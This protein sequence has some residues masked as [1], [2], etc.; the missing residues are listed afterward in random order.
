MQEVKGTEIDEIKKPKPEN[1]KNIKPENEMKMAS[2][3][4]NAE[5]FGKMNLK[6]KQSII[7]IMKID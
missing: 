1:F 7:M 4:K 5:V 6:K 3:E 2:R